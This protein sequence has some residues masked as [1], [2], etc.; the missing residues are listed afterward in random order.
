MMSRSC[1]SQR[2]DK[3]SWRKV[4]IINS[5]QNLLLCVTKTDTIRD[6]QYHP[7]ICVFSQNYISQW[8]ML[9]N[10]T[11]IWEMS[12]SWRLSSYGIWYRVTV[13]TPYGIWYRVTVTTPYGIWYRVTV[14]TP[15]HHSTEAETCSFLQVAEGLKLVS[16]VERYNMQCV[17]GEEIRAVFITQ[18]LTKS[19]RVSKFVITVKHST[20]VSR[21]Q[22]DTL[23]SVWRRSFVAKVFTGRFAAQLCFLLHDQEVEQSRQ[24]SVLIRILEAKP[25]CY[26][27]AKQCTDGVAEVWSIRMKW[28]QSKHFTQQTAAK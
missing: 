4:I 6:A 18:K 3:S 27:N 21:T 16:L 12:R 26:R 9:K 28:V 1:H 19:D 11:F 10:C 17:V 2:R 22:T 15:R 24:D 23:P 13:T 25:Q 20:S 7:E 8:N 14:T 5:F